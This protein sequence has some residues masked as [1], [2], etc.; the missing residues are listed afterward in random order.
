MGKRDVLTANLLGASSYA[1][2]LLIDPGPSGLPGERFIVQ[3]TE[4][5]SPCPPGPK[6]CDCW[7]IKQ[8]LR[9]TH[10]Q[11]R[12]MRDLETTL[13]EEGCRKACKTVACR[14]HPAAGNCAPQSYQPTRN[15]YI[16]NSSISIHIRPSNLPLGPQSPKY[17]LSGYLIKGFSTLIYISGSET[18]G[19]TYHLESLTPI[20]WRICV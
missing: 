8:T 14:P 9:G 20:V 7:P 4:G 3:A 5:N 10:F 15:G 11:G 2:H 1:R 6:S 12:E 16:L 19:C 13:K 17:L 18:L